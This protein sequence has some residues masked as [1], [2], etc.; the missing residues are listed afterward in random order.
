[1]YIV[2]NIF[3]ISG[4]VKSHGKEAREKEIDQVIA[5]WLV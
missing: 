3:F 2:S 4:T 1:M 5:H